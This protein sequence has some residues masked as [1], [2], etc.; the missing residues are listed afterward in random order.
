MV[1]I[2]GIFKKLIHTLDQISCTSTV[3]FSLD[4]PETIFFSLGTVRVDDSFKSL[5]PRFGHRSTSRPPPQEFASSSRQDLS[6][7]LTDSLNA[8]T[9]S[10]RNELNHRPSLAQYS[11]V[12]EQHAKDGFAYWPTDSYY[13]KPRCKFFS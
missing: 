1:G 8:S 9:W 2:G 11:N 7:S 12:Y 4:L 3:V 13:K 6:N 5:T 10:L